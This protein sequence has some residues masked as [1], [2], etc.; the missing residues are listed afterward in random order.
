MQAQANKRVNS[1]GFV[2][3]FKQQN[4]LSQAKKNEKAVL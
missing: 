1:A 4:T 2:K 3:K